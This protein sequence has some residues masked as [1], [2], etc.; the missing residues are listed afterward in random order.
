LF[1]ETKMNEYDIR[2]LEENFLA[3][4]QSFRK[5]Q[6]N[7][8]ETISMTIDDFMLKIVK[9]QPIYSIQTTLKAAILDK[10][11]ET[12]ECDRK[13]SSSSFTFETFTN[14]F[15]SLVD[16]KIVF[17]SKN[18]LKFITL[19]N[20]AYQRSFL[21]KIKSI[22]I[23]AKC[24]SVLDATKCLMSKIRN[25]EATFRLDGI[26]KDK[27]L[28]LIKNL[29]EQQSLSDAAYINIYE[30][31]VASNILFV[32]SNDL[33][34]VSLLNRKLKKKTRAFLAEN[35]QVYNGKR[36]FN[37]PSFNLSTS[38]SPFRLDIQTYSKKV[39]YLIH[40]VHD[41]RDLAQIFTSPKEIQLKGHCK[42]RDFY[43]LPLIWFEVFVGN[44]AT[45]NRYGSISFRINISKVFAKGRAHFGLGTRKYKSE[46]THTIL[47]TNR[48]CVRA[49]TRVK[50]RKNIYDKLAQIMRDYSP[51]KD[52]NYKLPKID[53]EMNQLWIREN[54]DDWYL[55]KD[56]QLNDD[57][58]KR[59]PWDSVQLCLEANEENEEME[60]FNFAAF[61]LKDVRISFFEHGHEY[62]IR[63]PN[64]C[65]E[66]RKKAQ[67]DFVK[68]MKSREIPSLLKLYNCFDAR[69][70]RELFALYFDGDYRFESNEE[71]L[72]ELLNFEF[73]DPSIKLFSC[74]DS[75]NLIEE[76]FDNFSRNDLETILE[77]LHIKTNASSEIKRKFYKILRVS[78]SSSSPSTKSIEYKETA[79]STWL[80]R[81]VNIL[82]PIEVVS[83]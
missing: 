25:F 76:D 27:F 40:T 66:T 56:L 31:L 11:K 64:A 63:N 8:I 77:R 73:I 50:F 1:E 45:K 80:K 7:T 14:L 67:N 65:R 61:E 75:M 47:I 82:S 33:E 22:E 13:K 71:K 29:I 34:L 21:E 44:E 2:K 51:L 59:V 60:K 58:N 10:I 81:D 12:L 53:I 43:G 79:S 72:V 37:F 26:V 83:F 32:S 46:H 3:K 41:S 69:T 19:L 23:D 36:E 24:L 15:K 52:F 42:N 68:L 9:I 4:L 17:V 16:T 38:L 57:F 18:D 35:S 39:E 49:Q 6:E 28:S 48:E 5:D 62:C 20:R 74:K 30:A 78:V 54:C 70:F 55:N